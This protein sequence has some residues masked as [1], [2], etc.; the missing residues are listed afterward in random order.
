MR[1]KNRL[2]RQFLNTRNLADLTIFNQYRNKLN[3]NLRIA[4]KEYFSSFVDVRSALSELLWDKLNTLPRRGS[5]SCISKLTMK[6]NDLHG[7]DLADA[8][9]AF[10]TNVSTSGSSPDASQCVNMRN[11]KSLFLQPVTVHEVISII[12]NIKQQQYRYWWNL[13]KTCK[14]FRRRKCTSSCEYI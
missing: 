13:N 5:R 2:Y 11:D 4:R 3:K 7:A 8:F 6:G 12:T 10:F 9:N 14:I 1:R